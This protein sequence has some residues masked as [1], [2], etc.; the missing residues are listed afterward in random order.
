LPEKELEL[1][2]SARGGRV[3]KLPETSRNAEY[4]ANGGTSD[5]GPF[6]LVRFLWASNENEQYDSFFSGQVLSYIFQFNNVMV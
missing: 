6:L 2:E 5:R 4:P 3:F 1:F